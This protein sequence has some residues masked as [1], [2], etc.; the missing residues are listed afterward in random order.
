M[1]WSKWGRHVLTHN[2]LVNSAFSVKRVVRSLKVASLVACHLAKVC[3]NCSHHSIVKWPSNRL[4]TWSKELWKS[5]GQLVLVSQNA[6]PSLNSFLA[7]EF[8]PLR[9]RDVSGA[10]FNNMP[11]PASS[12]WHPSER[13]SADT[14]QE[15]PNSLCI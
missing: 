10:G 2:S 8:P 3:R 9:I 5:F 4:I 1:S 13:E 6:T 11:P 12:D 15:V 7:F 14:W